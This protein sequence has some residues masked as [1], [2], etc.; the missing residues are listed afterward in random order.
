MVVVDAA[1][2]PGGQSPTKNAFLRLCSVAEHTLDPQCLVQIWH[3]INAIE[4]LSVQGFNGTNFMAFLPSSIVATQ[5]ATRLRIAHPMVG[6]VFAA[7]P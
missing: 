4:N 3:K 7:A 5:G 1:L 2:I 6:N